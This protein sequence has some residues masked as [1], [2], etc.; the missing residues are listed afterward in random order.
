ME[1]DVGEQ[2]FEQ[3]SQWRTQRSQLT[4]SVRDGTDKALQ[5]LCTWSENIGKV[6]NDPVPLWFG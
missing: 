5:A 3:Y 6:H 4:S 2:A 1:G